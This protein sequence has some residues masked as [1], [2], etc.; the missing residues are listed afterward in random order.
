MR[1]ALPSLLLIS[2]LLLSVL[3]PDAQASSPVAKTLSVSIDNDIRA[4]LKN[5]VM[6]QRDLKRA[7]ARRNAKSMALVLG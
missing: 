1:S 2:P 4:P 3:I 6:P 5:R 7:A